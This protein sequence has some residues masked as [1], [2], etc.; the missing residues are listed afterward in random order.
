MKEFF[1]LLFSALQFSFLR[2]KCGISKGKILFS[3]A[4]KNFSASIKYFFKASVPHF[5]ALLIGVLVF[6]VG[7]IVLLFVFGNFISYKNVS[8]FEIDYKNTCIGYTDNQSLLPNIVNEIKSEF[9]GETEIADELN[10][11]TVK[12][13]KFYNLLIKNVS[14]AELKSRIFDYC[15]SITNAKCVYID[16]TRKFCAVGDKTI[17]KVIINFKT[18]RAKVSEDIASDFISCDFQYLNNLKVVSEYVPTKYVTKT[19]IYKTLYAIFKTDIHYRITAVQNEEEVIPYDTIYTRNEKLPAGAV[20][21]TK[22]G[23]DGVEQLQTKVVVEDGKLSEF[24]VLSKKILKKAVAQKVQIGN[25]YDSEFD[26]K[27][28]LPLKGTVTSPFGSRSDPINQSI[29]DHNGMDIA[30]KTGT[31]ILAAESGTVV[32]AS[33]SYYSYGKCVIIEHTPGF[34]TLYAHCSQLLVSEGDY[35]DAGDIIALVGSTGRATG[36]HLHFSVII[37]GK[38]VDPS[39]FL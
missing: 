3:N 24:T 13:V 1:Y 38:Y 4:R 39:D 20:K 32:K 37:K 22:K 35:V 8:Y 7:I 2:L 18:D 15:E 14:H 5:K 9:P 25:G 21:I 6:A 27:L 36:P 12:P 30:A 16:G 31:P 11:F 10:D 28:Y 34:R 19:D 17:N 33:E 23:S 29:S 26:D